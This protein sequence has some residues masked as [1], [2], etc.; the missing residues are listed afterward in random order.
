[1]KAVIKLCVAALLAVAL[2]IPQIQQAEAGRR[3]AGVAAGVAAGI[4]GLGILGAAAEAERRRHYHDGGYG[5]C[6]KGPRQCRIVGRDCYRDEYGDRVCEP[7]R[8]CYRQTYCD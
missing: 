3:G 7:V 1:M 6:Y 4:I 2:T 8:R 5:G